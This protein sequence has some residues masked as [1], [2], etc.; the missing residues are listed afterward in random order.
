MELEA[1]PESVLVDVFTSLKKDKNRTYLL[2][3]DFQTAC[4]DFK[5]KCL[6]DYYPD[7]DSLK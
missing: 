4:I 5:P 2:L 3:N 7:E 6:I 1:V